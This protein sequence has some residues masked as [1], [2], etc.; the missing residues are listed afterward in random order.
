MADKNNKLK[1]QSFALMPM[2]L[3]V[4]IPDTRATNDRHYIG[5][6]TKFPFCIIVGHQEILMCAE[7]ALERK[8]WMSVIKARAVDKSPAV[9]AHVPLSTSSVA[10]RRLTQGVFSQSQNLAWKQASIVSTQ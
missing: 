6:P 5:Y 10:F 4:T 7:N 8:R 2:N 9:V 1:V 3:K